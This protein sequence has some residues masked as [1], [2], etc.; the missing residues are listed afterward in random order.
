MKRIFIA[1]FLVAVCSLAHQAHSQILSV[2]AGCPFGSALAD[3]CPGAQANGTIIDAHLADAQ[4]VIDL[5]IDGGS[6]Y[7]NGTY[8]W[9]SSG[10]G[11]S[12]NASGTV[13][14]SG[15][16]LGGGVR[17]SAANYAITTRGAGCTSQP[18]IAIPAGAGAG[19]GGGIVATVYQLT[20]HN[21]TSVTACNSAVAANWN[22][23]GVDYPIGVDTTLTL[24]NPSVTQPSG[25][26][27]SS[28]TLTCTGG[29]TINGYAFSGSQ[30]LL[31]ST[32]T[33]T[34]T[35]SSFTCTSAS[36][37]SI[38]YM[39]TVA[40]GVSATF[41]YNTLNGG[42]VRTP[43][44]SPGIPCVSPSGLVAMIDSQQGNGDALTFEYNICYNFDA[45][46]GDFTGATPGTQIVTFTEK[47]NYYYG[48]G[49]CGTGSNSS[50]PCDH[51]QA[52][53]GYLTNNA[54]F[55]INWTSTFNVA[56]NHYYEGP[57]GLSGLASQVGDSYAQ[58]L[59]SQNNYR[60]ARGT[61]SYT[62]ISNADQTSGAVMFCGH[63]T[64]PLLGSLSG[65]MTN[66]ILEYSGANSAYNPSQS[67]C[68]ADIAP[69][70]FNAGTGH[71]CG[72]TTCN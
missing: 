1:L 52:W 31:L 5:N 6:G 7:T 4:A 25:C 54:T 66:S 57:T 21:C 45:V 17:G 20:P 65:T 22:V 11:C 37:Q 16:Q 9:T 30:L 40:K 8:A 13:T 51:G 67:T 64:D 62:G 29:G 28:P 14:V 38:L 44:V 60:M 70:D 41:K 24:S 36:G 2:G 68:Q 33:W 69:A 72:V 39:V 43:G 10:G 35:N 61:Q 53:Y 71:A 19:T 59:T 47:Y 48:L 46:C 27:W 32:G 12:P 49:I 56:L 55:Q 18:T 26:T 34:V 50:G 3:G 23:A 42:A 15:G 58:V 63:Q